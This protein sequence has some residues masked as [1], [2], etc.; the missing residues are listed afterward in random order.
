[1]HK[2]VRKTP[3]MFRLSVGLGRRGANVL[4]EVGRGWASNGYT[5]P[6]RVC[7]SIRTEGRS[8][9]YLVAVPSLQ[10]MSLFFRAVRALRPIPG[11]VAGLASCTKD[12]SRQTKSSHRI[13]SYTTRDAE[14]A[15]GYRHA[16]AAL[17]ISIFFSSLLE[18]E[19]DLNTITLVSTLL[20]KDD[21]QKAIEYGHRQRAVSIYESRIARLIVSVGLFKVQLLDL[22]FMCCPTRLLS[23]WPTVIHRGGGFFMSG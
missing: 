5:R 22:L 17:L 8:T 1:M 13:T 10:S 2:G 9:P 23:W 6:A 20:S 4:M 11:I 16:H 18:I 21:D 15:P 12:A 19:S 14:F 7:S 3:Q